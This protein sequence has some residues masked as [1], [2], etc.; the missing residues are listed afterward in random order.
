MGVTCFFRKRHFSISL[1]NKQLVRYTLLSSNYYMNKLSRATKWWETTQ[2]P[3]INDISQEA[4]IIG[5]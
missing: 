2:E 3:D 4:Q 1:S 5:T